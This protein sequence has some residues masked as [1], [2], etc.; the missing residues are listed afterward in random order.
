MLP[1]ESHGSLIVPWSEQIW[2]KRQQHGYH[3]GA[4]PQEMICPLVILTDKSSDYAGLTGCS[5]SKPDWWS[6]APVAAPVEA[7]ASTRLSCPQAVRRAFST[8]LLAAN[9]Q[10]PLQR[11]RSPTSARKRRRAGSTGLIASQA[12]RD[13]KALVRRHAPE[14]ALAQRCLIALNAQGGIMTPAAF[15]KAADLPEG[16]LDGLI[17]RMQRLLNVDGYEIL[18]FSRNE[19]R[20]EL[21]I[22]EAEAAI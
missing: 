3:G 19:N 21:N 18:T 12:Y 4:T 9:R 1:P 10:S 2:Y 15:A 5:Y 11:T 8:C 17:S 7:E 20:I 22:A 13:Q 6:P 16:R 14:D